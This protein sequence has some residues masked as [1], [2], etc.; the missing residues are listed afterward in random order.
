[1][2]IRTIKRLMPIFVALMFGVS[3]LGA[4]N[5]LNLNSASNTKILQNVV[6]VQINP[7]KSPKSA[8]SVS[9]ATWWNIKWTYRVNINVSCIYNY[10]D[11]LIQQNIDFTSLLQALG[12]TNT[13]LDNNSIRI[14]EWVNSLGVNEEIPSQFDEITSPAYDPI[15]NAQGTVSWVMNGT[16]IVYGVTP[17]IRTYFLYFDTV[18]NGLKQ[19][20]N[21][22]SDSQ[23]EI[24]NLGTNDYALQNA[25]IRIAMNVGLPPNGGADYYSHEYEVYDMQTG[26]DLQYAAENLGW[27]LYNWQNYG[28]YNQD[29]YDGVTNIQVVSSGPVKAVIQMQQTAPNYIYNR[30]YTLNYLSN[31][32]E[33]QHQVIAINAISSSSPGNNNY[34]GGY[35]S[36]SHWYFGSWWNPGYGGTN[37]N[38]PNYAYGLGGYNWGSYANSSITLPGDPNSTSEFISQAS[39]FGSN[40]LWYGWAPTS[41]IASV[42]AAGWFTEWDQSLDQGVGTIWDT[43]PNLNSNEPTLNRVGY[44]SYRNNAGRGVYLDLTPPSLSAGGNFT[45]TM[46]GQIYDNNNG[47]S[48]DYIAKDFKILQRSSSELLSIRGKY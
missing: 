44:Q 27:V 22:S 26:K 8:A 12:V 5:N 46:W 38:A 18:N 36:G 24:L 33:I 32:I 39:L 40:P 41:Q 2:N 25:K 48:T 30:Y 37:I 31:T 1:M 15:L 19:A 11:Y 43:N 7:L 20:P 10:T 34:F 6:P 28:G 9:T 14:I 17:T 21:Y 29:P 16:T 23:L 3:L 35:S 47:T 45:F 13:A 4:T 42:R